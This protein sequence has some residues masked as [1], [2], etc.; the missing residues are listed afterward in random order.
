[1]VVLRDD[2]F[3]GEA[4]APAR[5]GGTAGAARL[6]NPDFAA[7]ARGAGGVGLRVDRPEGLD[8]AL[9]QAF[10][11]ARAGRPTLLEVPVR[12]EVPTPPEPEGDLVRA[13]RAPA[14]PVG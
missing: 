2:A 1:V 6:T 13:G 4:H 7:Y 3:A 11:A 12:P 8:E 9:A 14:V 10:R 5:S